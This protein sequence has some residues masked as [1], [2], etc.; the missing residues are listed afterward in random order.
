MKKLKFLLFSLFFVLGVSFEAKANDFEILESSN[1]TIEL[2]DVESTKMIKE[3]A[4]EDGL[5]II[6]ETDCCIIIII[7]E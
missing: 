6:I 7:M 3:E 4:A 2:V 1:E 5:I